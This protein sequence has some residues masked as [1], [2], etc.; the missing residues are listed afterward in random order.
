MKIAKNLWKILA[1]MLVFLSLL[2]LAH[3]ATVYP[4]PD[5]S[6][7]A[8]GD[9]GSGFAFSGNDGTFTVSQGLAAGNYT[10]NVGHL[11]YMTTELNATINAGSQTDLGDIQ[12]NVSG[13]IRGAVQSSGGTPVSGVPLVA[14]DQSTND[15]KSFAVSTNDGS[16]IMNTDL[17][18]GTYTVEAF[19]YNLTGYSS[20]STTGISVTAGQPTSGVVIILGLSG[21]ISGTVKDESQTPIANVSVYAAP[22]GGFSLF[23]GGTAT[24]DS[25][26]HYTIGSNLP[27]G[28]Y[29]V[30]ILTAAGYVYSF[31]EGQ[32][33]T[34]T[35]EQ[36]STV[37]F[38]LPRSGIISGTVTLSGGGAA[39]NVTVYADTTGEPFYFGSSKTD[40]NGHYSIDSGLGT[41][42]Y[43]VFAGNDYLN[44][45]TINVTAGAETSNIDFTI[46]QNVAYIT[47][48]VT[49]STGS[50]ITTA[51]VEA[52]G[53]SVSGTGFTDENGNYAIQ[54]SD[55][56]SETSVNVT[57]TAKGYVDSSPQT[58]TINL[59][60]TVT[61]IDF[62]L[63]P[64]P[65]GTLR[66]RVV[67]TVIIPEFSTPTLMLLTTFVTSAVLIALVKRKSSYTHLGI[68]SGQ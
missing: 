39:I 63:N 59:G 4:L 23:S 5:S 24:T 2:T 13:T 1:I 55:I 15:T 48:T 57:A 62:T 58:V 6:I 66:G 7:S 18:T 45:Q 30:S 43:I 12:L 41:G 22:S 50:P 68:S 28:N 33:T 32:N 21:I 20:N 14:V 17:D 38:V 29:T 27:T 51:D 8:D 16:F 44:S 60:Q 31:G 65:T 10:V 56:T 25:N 52:I 49:N 53:E 42:E 34:V 47:G 3:A 40:N 11:G 46:T 61:G 9:N 35:A 54:I 64:A 67:A 19:T 37:N 26:G 36:P